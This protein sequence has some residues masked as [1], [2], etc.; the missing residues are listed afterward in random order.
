MVFYEVN[1]RRELEV[2]AI[3]QRQD[4]VDLDKNDRNGNYIMRANSARI[5][6]IKTKSS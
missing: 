2:S 3:I 6:I 4:D 1:W 5:H